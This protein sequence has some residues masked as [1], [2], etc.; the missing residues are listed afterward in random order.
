MP[1]GLA[2]RAR[3]DEACRRFDEDFD[4]VMAA[5]P[6]SLE[7]PSVGADDLYEAVDGFLA[8]LP[9]D[10]PWYLRRMLGSTTIRLRDWDRTVRLTV[11]GLEDDPT[12]ELD[13]DVA[14][15]SSSLLLCIEHRYGLNT[16]GVSG[17][18]HKPAG[19]DY[20]RFHRFSRPGL[21]AVRGE[22]VGIGYI[23]PR[24]STPFWC[25]WELVATSRPLPTEVG[26]HRPVSV[27]VIPSGP[28]LPVAP[29]SM[30][31]PVF[32]IVSRR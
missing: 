21:I 17:R 12:L 32:R 19:G 9:D 28:D 18:F 31:F 4:R 23:V 27:C 8:R 14:L 20:R 7:D 15:H 16:L 3:G 25:G 13:T 24:C 22:V 6:L 5:G 2:I 10:A 11:D 26:G 29:A 30:T 1:T